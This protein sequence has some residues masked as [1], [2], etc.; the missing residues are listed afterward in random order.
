[1]VVIEK[2]N[3]S[4]GYNVFL[5]K[6]NDKMFEI[7]FQNNGD[8]YWRYI[9]EKN[10]LE[11]PE[12]IEFVITKENYFLYH[13]FYKLYESVKSGKVYYG[14]EEDADSLQAKNDE[15][16]KNG[17]IDWYSDDS[18]YEIASRLIIKKENDI[19]RVIFKKSKL[20]EDEMFVTYTV[21]FRNSGSRYNPFNI[22]FMNMYNELKN[23]EP[24][25]HQIHIE[26]YLYDQKVLKK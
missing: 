18:Y 12:N 13:L 9:Y 22:S 2:F 1:M 4:H 14:L 8:L 11:C 25:Y 26:E 24:E 17:V 7:S 10:I 3:N 6:I 19:F 16:F 21:R 23:Y 20:S 5:I 15:L